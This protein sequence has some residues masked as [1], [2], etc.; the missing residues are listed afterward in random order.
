MDF[1]FLKAIR[2]YLALF[3]FEPT[4]KKEKHVV[5]RL[6]NNIVTPLKIKVNTQFN[7]T[8]TQ[9]SAFEITIDF[10]GTR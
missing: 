3:R 8:L 6:T 9:K 5:H 7:V 2:F 1:L 4:P 10:V